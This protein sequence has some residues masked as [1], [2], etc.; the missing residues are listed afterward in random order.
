MSDTLE[1]IKNMK[2]LDKLVRKYMWGHH[3]N[4]MWFFHGEPE[5]DEAFK[6]L[7]ELYKTN[8]QLTNELIMADEMITAYV[9]KYGEL[10]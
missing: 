3:I 2:S 1:E 6:E 5:I 4:G 7:A 9:S 10:S 8:E